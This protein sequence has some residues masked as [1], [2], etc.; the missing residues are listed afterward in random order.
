[1]PF[2][3]RASSWVLSRTGGYLI[4][5]RKIDGLGIRHLL[6]VVVISE[7]A[8]V[9]K[10]DPRIFNDALSRLGVVPSAAAYV[11]DNP[12][13]DVLGA[14]RSGLLAI[15]KRDNFW[16]EP[17]NCDSVIDDLNE[18]PSVLASASDSTASV[19]V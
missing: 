10:P 9:R 17:G 19:T 11:G 1:M 7:S 15:W 2:E 8:G 5:G 3:E 14:K 4:Q 16:P 13:V 6:D 12:D 18:L